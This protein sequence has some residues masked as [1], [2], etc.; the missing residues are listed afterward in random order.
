MATTSVLYGAATAITISAATL[1]SGAAR[2]SAAVDNTANKYDD[3]LVQLSFTIGSGAPS[4][5]Q[6][7]NVYASSSY[8]GTTWSDNATGTDSAITLR[9]PTNLRLIGVIPTPTA[10]VTY[11]SELLSVAAA[12]GGT[13]PPHWSIIVD[14]ETG[15]AFTA[16]SLKYMGVNET[17]A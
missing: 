15:D 14:N 8:D 10:S 12:F 3:A 11:V 17:V 16:C 5:Q 9:S 6:A 2:E 4:G 1:A 7:V 13:L